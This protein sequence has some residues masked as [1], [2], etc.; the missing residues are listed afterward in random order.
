MHQQHFTLFLATLP[1]VFFSYTH[2]TDAHRDRVGVLAKRLSVD[3]QG[4]SIEIIT[5]HSLPPGGP[6]EDFRRWSERNAQDSNLVIP[7]FNATYR[8][9]WDGEHPSGVRNGGTNE[10]TVIAAR[11]NRAG[12][13]LPFIR[14]VVF[15]AADKAHIP[16]R[17]ANLKKFIADR[18]YDLLLAWI[19]D[20]LI[21]PSTGGTTVGTS[22]G[23]SFP[24]TPATVDRQGFINCTPAF[25]AFE[26]MLTAA[27]STSILLL[28]SPG[29]HGKSE[30]IRRLWQHSR[31]ILGTKSAATTQFKQPTSRPEDCLRDMARALGVPVPVNHGSI[32]EH[33]DGVLDACANRSVVLFFDV[34]DEAE[35]HHRYWVRRVL[36]RC[37]DSPNLRCV[38]A[39]RDIPS[40]EGQ[41]WGD[42]AVAEECD[43]FRDSDS[44]YVYACS[45]GF[46]GPRE[47]IQTLVQV[48]TDLREKNGLTP[49]AL[50]HQIKRLCPGGGVSS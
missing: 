17:L 47:S 1:T 16:D 15:D 33:V 19:R 42:L 28:R 8:K 49:K 6:D 4:T 25:T 29:E 39:G 38:V 32:D 7:V 5:D 24:D 20:A 34:Y 26:N 43:L 9:C 36:S 2:D 41:T 50:L 23:S 40:P 35:D 13:P 27:S 3:L 48:F 44:I 14:V 37:V 18:D 31:A 12:G 22:T 45:L 30:L 21:P 46:S 10:A 11:V